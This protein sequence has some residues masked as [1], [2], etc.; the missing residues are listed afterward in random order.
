MKNLILSAIIISCLSHNNLFGQ[1]ATTSADLVK[2]GVV[3]NDAGKFDEA[4]DKYKQAL[5][6]DPNNWQADYEMGYTLY[7]TGHGKDAIPYLQK[8][9]SSTAPKYEA[10]DLLGSIYD[11]NNEPQK[12]VECYKN[13][14]ADNPNFEH[15]HFNLGISY[16]RQNK[17]AEAEE[18]EKDAI[19]LDQRHAS[20]QRIYAM[21]TYAGQKRIYA[22]MAWCSFLLLEPN[23]ARSVEAYRNIRKILNYGI[24][25]QDAKHTN[26]SISEKEIGTSTLSMQ[27]AVLAATEGKTNLSGVDSLNL[28]L[29]TMFK[30]A[31]EFKETQSDSFF[32][33]YYAKFFNKLA[34][35]GNMEAFTRFISLSAYKDENLA[36][37]KANNDKLNNLDMWIR[38]NPRTFN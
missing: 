28:Q 22:L 12:A 24:S 10:D 9:L 3:L 38:T 5:A 30:Q 4:I 26:I 35:S 20:S 14:I 13:G 1:T 27:M 6:I 29:T 8:I 21:A 37:F 15:L 32:S 23:T 11:D 25:Q 7:N 36:W 31:F 33:N 16:Y 34:E 19:K 17:Y 2:Q 18:C